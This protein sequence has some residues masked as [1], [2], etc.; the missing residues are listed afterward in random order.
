MLSGVHHERDRAALV[1]APKVFTKAHQIYC[2]RIPPAEGE[3]YP[4]YQV[5]VETI[6]TT[7]S[8]EIIA[9]RARALVGIGIGPHWGMSARRLRAFGWALIHAADRIDET[10]S[11]KPP[12]PERLPF[13]TSKRRRRR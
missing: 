4:R 11:A 12:Q 7:T 8:D 6:T 5:E 2:E 9:V 1:T 13:P 10:T 3:T